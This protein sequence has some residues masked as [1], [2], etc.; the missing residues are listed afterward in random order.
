MELDDNKLK[1]FIKKEIKKQLNN[2]N[3]ITEELSS[4]EKTTI[5]R[6]IRSEV[7]KIMRTLWKKRN[8]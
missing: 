8:L 6:I 4:D 3:T 2:K 1:H 5:R 7:A